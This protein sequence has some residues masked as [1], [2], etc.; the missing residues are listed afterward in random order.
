MLNFWTIELKTREAGDGR[1]PIT[2]LGLIT[3]C[4]VSS[5]VHTKFGQTWRTSCGV[6]RRADPC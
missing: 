5:Q 2:D 4:T 1:W 6:Y 3:R